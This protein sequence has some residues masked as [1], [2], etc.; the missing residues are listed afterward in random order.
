MKVFPFA[1]SLFFFS[2]PPAALPGPRSCG[3]EAA[4]NV[5]LGFLCGF[6]CLFLALPGPRP[7]KKRAPCPSFV[8]LRCLLGTLALFLLQGLLRGLLA[9][10]D[11]YVFGRLNLIPK[12][13]WNP[14]GKHHSFLYMIALFWICEEQHALCFKMCR[15][16][17]KTR[18][19][20]VASRCLSIM[21]AREDIWDL[22]F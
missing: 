18:D 20:P 22:Y 21:S 10:A 4:V 15:E 19:E 11:L 3:Q 9:R 14:S 2:A 5:T 1:F 12:C 17:W 13:L 8:C 7:G 6:L 16:Q